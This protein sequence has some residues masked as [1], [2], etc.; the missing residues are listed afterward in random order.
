MY[1]VHVKCAV[2]GNEVATHK[3]PSREI[4]SCNK[5]AVR[6]IDLVIP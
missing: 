2:T 4:R 6:V 1:A 3:T 5:S